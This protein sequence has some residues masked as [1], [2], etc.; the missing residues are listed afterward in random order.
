MKPE[1]AGAALMAL[2]RRL[3]K[4]SPRGGP[5][6]QAEL[7]RAVS[8]AY[9]SLFHELRLD[10][11]DFLVGRTPV[12]RASAAWHTVFRTLDLVGRAST[13]TSHLQLLDFYETFAEMKQKRERADYDSNEDFDP[14]EAR[15]TVA[16]AVAARSIY[17]RVP[18]ADRR[19]A[20]AIVLGL[21][22]R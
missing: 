19:A 9:Y 21:K 12:S 6:R 2:A 7:R 16:T 15:E 11:A 18:T 14:G 22:R 4:D 10:Y 8:T 17:K 5:L 20:I 1:R 13:A 3:S